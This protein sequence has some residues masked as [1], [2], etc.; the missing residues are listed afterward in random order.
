M[1][2]RD[3]PDTATVNATI[4]SLECDTKYYYWVRSI[5]DTVGN[6]SFNWGYSPWRLDSFTTPK[7]CYTPDVT[8]SYITSTSAIASWNPVPSVVD[9]EYAMRSDTV[10]YTHLDVYKRQLLQGS[11]F[12]L[13]PLTMGTSCHGIY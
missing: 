3:R 1:C 13:F 6:S 10:S 7:C 5:C 4:K 2:I 12:R 11:R 8:I 9:Y